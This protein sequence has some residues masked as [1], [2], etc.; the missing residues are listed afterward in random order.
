M[1]GAHFQGV[2]IS[3]KSIKHVGND[4][5]KTHYRIW[6]AHCYSKIDISLY[7]HLAFKYLN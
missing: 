1:S 5:L 6:R 3:D 7:I 2:F 4:G